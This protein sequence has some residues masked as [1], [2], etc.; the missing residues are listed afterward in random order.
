MNHPI[1]I[2]NITQRITDLFHYFFVLFD[3]SLKFEIC[4]FFTKLFL[5]FLLLNNVIIIIRENSFD[6]SLQ[7]ASTA[8]FKIEIF[9]L[10]QCVKMSKYLL[11]I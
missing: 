1:L 5:K 8:V 3:A 11:I 2:R 9:V 7:L 6:Q 4:V 10:K